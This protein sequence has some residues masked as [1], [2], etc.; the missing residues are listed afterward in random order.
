ML[1]LMLYSDVGPDDAPTRIGVGS[2]V[3]IAR[4]LVQFGERGTSFAD[5]AS[6]VP[7]PAPETVVTATGRAGDAYLCHPFLLH[8]A[9]WPHRGEAPRFMGQPCMSHQG[10]DG[11]HYDPPT[12]PCEPAVVEALGGA[13]SAERDELA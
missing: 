12:S 13:Q 3:A 8:A 5:A 7:Q 2:H 6:A 9:S 4:A 1:L 11:Y 10:H